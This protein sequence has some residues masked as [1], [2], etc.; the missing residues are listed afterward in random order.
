MYVKQHCEEELVDA[1]LKE[2]AGHF[3]GDICRAAV[4]FQEG[5][6]YADLDLEPRLPFHSLIDQSTHFMSV[7]TGDHA[8]LN[9]LMATAPRSAVMKETLEQLRQWYK[10]PAHLNV[11]RSEGEWMGTVTLRNAL[12]TVIKAKCPETS[13][14]LQ[15]QKQELQWHCGPGEFRFYQES[16]LACHAGA[17]TPDCPRERLASKFDG[18]RYGIYMLGKENSKRLVAWSRMASCKEWWCGGR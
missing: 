9:A 3:R 12:D 4:L 14:N 5:G 15:V 13:F 11:K 18:L 16:K 8:I 2:P 7:V 10:A 17:P 1:Y 6:F